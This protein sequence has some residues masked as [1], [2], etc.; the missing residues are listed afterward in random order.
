VSGFTVIRIN[1]A[2]ARAWRRT[3]MSVGSPGARK[4]AL[5]CGWKRRRGAA[6]RQ[7]AANCLSTRG[8]MNTKPMTMRGRRLARNEADSHPFFMAPE[9]CGK[10]GAAQNQQPGRP[11]PEKTGK[12]CA[13]DAE[14]TRADTWSVVTG[15][16]RRNAEDDPL[17]GR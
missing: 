8:R 13:I 1:D 15:R 17:P 3:R 16:P 11:G 5:W 14:A 9:T 12:R 2:E 7:R 10:V 4:K 6:F